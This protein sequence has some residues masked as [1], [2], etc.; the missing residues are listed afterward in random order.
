MYVVLSII[1]AGIIFDNPWLKYELNP[2]ANLSGQMGEVV[3]PPS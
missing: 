1:M 3:M 2:L